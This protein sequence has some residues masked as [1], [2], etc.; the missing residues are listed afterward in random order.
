[1]STQEFGVRSSVAPLR[2][3]AVRTP[4]LVGD[5]AAAHWAGPDLDQLLVDHA[6]FVELLRSLGTQVEVLAPFDGWPDA[7]FVY[8]P[9]FVVP[10]GTIELRAAKVARAGE[11][12]ALV[13]DLE[14]LGVP[15]VGRLSPEATAD[16]GDMFWLDEHTLAVGRTYRTNDEAIAQLRP[17]LALDNI[18]V[19]TFDLP[20]D[21]GPEFCLH[22]MSVISPVRD[23]LA[24]V[25]PKLAPI[26]LLQELDRRGIGTVEVPD[27][28]YLTL[29]CNVLAVSPGVVVLPGG[30]DETASRLEAAGVEVHMY[31]AGETNKGEGG[32]TCLTRPILRAE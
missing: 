12:P 24:V 20:H 21:L 18:D 5:Y 15:T 23:D 11:P 26:R 9:A 16:G 32:P 14:S 27:D 17:L 22:L 31:A 1:M 3:V 2:R 6:A 19:V 29:G 13:A 8:D 30:N 4:T 25:Y 28:E 7:T 10:S